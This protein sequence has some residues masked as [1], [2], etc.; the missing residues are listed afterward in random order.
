MIFKFKQGGSAI[1]PFV[2]YQPVMVANDETSE[3]DDIVE[4]SKSSKGM[5][6]IKTWMPALQQK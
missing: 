1:P 3:D 4:S 5:A 6:A 2:S